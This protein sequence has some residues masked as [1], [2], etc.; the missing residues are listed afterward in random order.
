M[1]SDQ[2]FYDPVL[3]FEIF[4]VEWVFFGGI[5]PEG[6]SDPIHANFTASIV[7]WIGIFIRNKP[8]FLHHFH[9]DKI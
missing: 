6:I 5:F 9:Y 3:V 2:V 4:Y 7:H 1:A 8:Q